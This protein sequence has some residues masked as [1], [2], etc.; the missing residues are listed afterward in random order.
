[1]RGSTSNGT[2]IAVRPASTASK[3]ALEAGERWS[4]VDGAM[5]ARQ[6]DCMVENPYLAPESVELEQHENA[7]ASLP[8]AAVKRATN[9][10]R[11]SRLSGVVALIPLL[12]LIFI[13][14]LVQWYQLRKQFPILA[15]SEAGEHADL[16]KQ[17]RKAL[18]SLW[19]AVLLWPAVFLFLFV[20]L[21]LT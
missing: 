1:M 7:A 20:Y 21:A 11:D 15:S 5:S 6:N 2:P 3:W 18:F 9:L 14:R 4:S 10:V 19:F 13:L 16:A 8:P 17:F 12:G